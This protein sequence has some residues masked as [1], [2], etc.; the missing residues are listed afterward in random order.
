MEEFFKWRTSLRIRKCFRFQVWKSSKSMDISDTNQ[1]QT[2]SF[3]SFS[4]DWIGRGDL[5][6]SRD[7]THRGQGEDFDIGTQDHQISK[8]CGSLDSQ[9]EARQSYPNAPQTLFQGNL[10]C[11]VH[12]LWAGAR[13]LWV[14]TDQFTISNSLTQM[15]ATVCPWHYSLTL[16]KPLSPD[17]VN[18][19]IAPG[20]VL[21]LLVIFW[22]GDVVESGFTQHC[23]SDSPSEKWR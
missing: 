3:S 10:Y 17:C 18:L 1:S 14:F 6:I 5:G 8:C 16:G 12:H 11:H 22:N 13:I 4:H 2:G 9:M 21:I 19:L 7:H 15:P 20:Q 23:A